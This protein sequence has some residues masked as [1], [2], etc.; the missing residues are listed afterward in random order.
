LQGYKVSC[1]E[2][3]IRHIEVWILHKS[4]CHLFDEVFKFDPSPSMGYT[5]PYPRAEDAIWRKSKTPYYW[6]F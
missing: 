4:I 3:A 2:Y 1:A 6:G 5:I